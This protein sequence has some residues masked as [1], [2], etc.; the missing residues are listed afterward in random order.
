METL[1]E[2]PG[3]FPSIA[4]FQT[5]HIWGWR[6]V[7]LLVKDV[8]VPGLQHNLV[9]AR[10]KARCTQA[11]NNKRWL[12]ISPLRLSRPRTLIRPRKILRV[13]ARPAIMVGKPIGSIGETQVFVEYAAT[14]LDDIVRTQTSCFGGR[15]TN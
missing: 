7:F 4:Y 5:S 3:P 10:T 2:N 11:N 9:L 1:A 6:S 13:F 8:T 12:L 15:Y 14:D